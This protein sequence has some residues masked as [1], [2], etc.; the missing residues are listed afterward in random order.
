FL[1]GRADV[2]DLPA[3]QVRGD[4]EPE[5]VFGQKPAF[6]FHIDIVPVVLGGQARRFDHVGG[7]AV[8][9]AH[10]FKLEVDVLGLVSGRIGVGDIGRDELLTAGQQVHVVF[11]F[12]SDSIQHDRYKARG[13]PIG[14]QRRSYSVN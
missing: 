11:Q 6:A 14:F 4:A 12:G 9:Q 1:D 7:P 3:Q 8:H 13:A 5:R 2:P 10:E